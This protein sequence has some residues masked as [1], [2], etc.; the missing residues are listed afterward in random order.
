M[1]RIIM[2]SLVVLTFCSGILG[3][4]G[5]AQ[6]QSYPSKAIKMIV[7]TPPGSLVDLLA[8]IISDNF[9]KEWGQQVIIQNIGGAGA[10]IGSARIAKAKGDGY[11]LGFVPANLS[12]HPSLYKITYNVPKDFTPISQVAGASLVMYVSN[13]VSAK[14]LK[15]TI[16]LAKSK[17]GDLTYA[18]AGKGSIAHLAGELFKSMASVNVVRVP[19]KKLNLGVLDVIKGRVS[20]VFVSAAQGMPHVRKGNLKAIGI[21]SM[22]PNPGAKGVPPLAKLGLPG[23][24][25][26]SWFGVVGPKGIP[27]PIVEKIHGAIVKMS[28]TAKFKTALAKPGLEPIISTPAEFQAAL[29]SEVQKFAKIIKATGAK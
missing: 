14:T 9:K 16:A 27:K 2:A 23:Y 25:L 24:E 17:P 7:P 13:E 15:E 10:S 8:R 20:M 6:A 3:A 21:T 1:H 5:Y 28:K 22:Q 18:S 19:Y 26:R 29:A 12:T 11:T 4:T